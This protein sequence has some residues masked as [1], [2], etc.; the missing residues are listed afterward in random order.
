MLEAHVARAGRASGPGARHGAA[1]SRARRR[2][3]RPWC[4]AAASTRSGAA[5]CR[6]PCRTAR[7]PSSC[8]TPS[9]SW[10]SS[11]RSPTSCSWAAAC[12]ARW[13]QHARAGVAR[14][15]GAVRALHDEFPR[16]GVD[17]ARRTAAAGRSCV[18]PASSATELCRLLADPRCAHGAAAP[19][20]SGGLASRRG[21]GHAGPR[22][23]LSLPE[24]GAGVSAR[25]RLLAG[26]GA[27]V[28]PRGPAAAGRDGRQLSRPARR[29]RVAL[30][31]RDAPRSRRSTVPVVSIGNLTV[32]GTGKT[33]AVELAVRTLMDLGHRPGVL[34]RGLRPAGRRTCR[35]SPTRP[36]F[37]WMP[38]RP[39]MSRS[40]WPGGCPACRWSWAPTATR[41][42]DWRARGSA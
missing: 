2:G 10:R 34:S 1:P 15:A 11:T 17:P 24:P 31:A 6:A 7:P 33:P 27:R 16:G 32:G 39:A 22:R 20:G 38:R 30:R 28:Q 37:A 9:A 8:S 18:T 4:R 25:Q 41:R 40:C 14:Q 12:R 19:H 13:P 3:D 23:P 5:S 29:P 42:G 21:A 26:L 35:S 36:R